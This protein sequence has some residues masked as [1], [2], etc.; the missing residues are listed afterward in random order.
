MIPLKTQAIQNALTG[1]WDKAIIIN[2]EI[3]VEE[4]TDI[5]TLNRLGFAYTILGKTK[6]AKQIYQQVLDIDS[7]NPIALKNLKK[8][9]TI[10]GKTK[11]SLHIS[12][13]MF[14]E[15]SGKTKIV[16]LV[17][18]APAQVLKT[19]QMGQLL[20]LCIKRSKV[21]VQDEQKQFVGMLPDDIGKRL[22]RFLEGG[23][24]YESY[25]KSAEDHEVVIFIKEVKR[26]A[27]F[28]NQPSF[29][30]GDKTKLAFDMKKSVQS[31]DEEETE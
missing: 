8:L 30:F 4:P 22:T 26:A 31:L 6:E 14:L 28:K 10:G 21:F 7:A 25:V 23:N 3:L 24:E 2:Q 16:T 19:L 1:D 20:H 29:L 5:D 13:N 9:G 15:E 27:K 12:T 18:T 17:N 11:A